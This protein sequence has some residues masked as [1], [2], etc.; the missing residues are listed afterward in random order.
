[1]A[2]TFARRRLTARRLKPEALPR[3][4]RD[5]G[6][7]LGERLGLH[8]QAISG[9]ELQVRV[10]LIR[11]GGSWSLSA[12]KTPKSRRRIA[13]S[14]TAQKALKRQRRLQAEARL[15]AGPAWTDHGLVFTDEFGEPLTGSRITARR[16]R[17]LLRREGLPP[18]R[19]HDLRHTAATL[20]LTAGVNPKVVSEMLGH[21]SVAITLDR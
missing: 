6:V 14:T 8:W 10:A 7:R 17:P 2:L 15:R 4:D 12:P 5:P 11:V 3:D 1:M 19:F 18:I 13:L 9:T 20:M 21:T 16:L